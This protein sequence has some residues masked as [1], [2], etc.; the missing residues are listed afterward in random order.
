LAYAGRPDYTVPVSSGTLVATSV[1]IG[2]LVADDLIVLIGI[3]RLTCAGQTTH[4]T[5]SRR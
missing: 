1:V 2:Q 3:A 5:E 4:R